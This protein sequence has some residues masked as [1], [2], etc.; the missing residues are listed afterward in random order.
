MQ[1]KICT[2]CNIEK[3]ITEFH[4]NRLGKDGYYCQCKECKNNYK[5]QY[6]QKNQDKRREYR[7]KNKHIGLWRSVL[8]MSLWR[9]N[10]KKEGYTIDLL[11]YSALEFKKHIELLFTEGMS[12][13]NHG[14]WHVDHIKPVSSFDTTEHPSVVNALENLRPMWSTTRVINDVYYEGNLNRIKIKRK[15]L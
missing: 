5:K 11:G 9:L 1:S 14:E 3:S 8:K 15:K 4:V 7:L 6:N 10:T 2:K 13:D 12:W